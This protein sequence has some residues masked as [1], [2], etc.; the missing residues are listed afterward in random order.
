MCYFILV[1]LLEIFN[2]LKFVLTP[3][4]RLFEV[5]DEQHD[6]FLCYLIVFDFVIDLRRTLRVEVVLILFYLL[7]KKGR[8]FH[9]SMQVI[10][11][12]L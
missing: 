2:I 12:N 1:K 4:K 11:V 10:A 3:K 6:V 7:Q 5:L 9:F 8:V